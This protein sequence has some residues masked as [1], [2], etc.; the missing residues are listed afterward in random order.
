VLRCG[1]RYH[2]PPDFAVDRPQGSGDWVWVQF[3]SPVYL[4]DAE[5]VHHLAAGA[6]IIHSPHFPHWYSGVENAMEANWMHFDGKAVCAL[7]SSCDL[8]C[9]HAFTPGV[10]PIF[11]ALISNIER[12]INRGELF[13]E[14]TSTHLAAQLLFQLS[15]SCKQH[16][17]RITA[18][19]TALRE[20]L[21]EVR[22]QVLRNPRHRWTVAEMAL[23]AHLSPSRFAALYRE[24]FGISPLEDVLR[25]RME[26]ACWLLLNTNATVSQ[27]AQECSFDSIA[28][29]SRTFTRRIG[30]SPRCYSKRHI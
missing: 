28:H 9:D 13:A 17:L 22:L 15:R 7:L 14:E 1:V 26:R 2:H 5:G 25:S 8:K 11:T 3:L 30:C 24:F 10:N 29:F 18:H 21:Q 23:H 16:E 6:H 12:E 19:Q 4:R 27:V 20:V